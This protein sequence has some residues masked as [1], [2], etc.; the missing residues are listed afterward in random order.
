VITSYFVER[1]TAL[2]NE[3][4]PHWRGPK[5]A[6]WARLRL[7]TGQVARSAW[8]EKEKAAEKIRRARC[9]KVSRQGRA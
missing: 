1:E 6:R 8:K 2:G 3:V 5:I 4:P 9:V 7:P